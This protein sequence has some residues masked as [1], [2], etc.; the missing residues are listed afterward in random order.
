MVKLGMREGYYAFFLDILIRIVAFIVCRFVLI[1][2]DFSYNS[3][4]TYRVDIIEN[5]I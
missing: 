1:W 2:F 3:N 4:I 5:N